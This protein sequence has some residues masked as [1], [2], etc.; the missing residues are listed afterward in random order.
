M[1]SGELGTQGY[2]DDNGGGTRLAVFPTITVRL[3]SRAEIS[4]QLYAQ[5]FVS[6][7]AYWSLAEVSDARAHDLD[8]RISRFG[9]IS[10]VQNGELRI[11]RGARRTRLTLDDPS[12]TAREHESNAV[13]RS[14]YRPGSTLFVV[15]A[16]SRDD[17][18]TRADCSI[19]RQARE[20]WKTRGTDVLLIKAS[21]WISP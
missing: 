15:W 18:T 19:S 7:G 2:V 21:Y 17:D 12:F 11:D 5:P 16:Q 6:A 14:E 10:N 8:R 13:L 20:L 4:L 3:S 1:V 9:T